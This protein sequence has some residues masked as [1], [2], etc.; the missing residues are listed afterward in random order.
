M[1]K[2]LFMILIVLFAGRAFSRSPLVSNI[3]VDS[4]SPRVVQI[5][6]DVYNH[7]GK[8]VDMEIY[9]STDGGEHYTKRLSSL[10]GDVRNVESGTNKLIK[11]D[12]YQDL[13]AVHGD[14]FRLKVVAYSHPVER[15]DIIVNAGSLGAVAAALQAARDNPEAEILLLEP[16]DWLGGQAT[17][18][19]VSAIDN[20]YT[21]HM[22]DTPE[23][24]AR[25]WMEFQEL[26]RENPEEAPGTG[27]AGENACWVSRFSYDPR[28]GAWAFE[29]MIE[30][31]P[32]ITYRDMSVVKDVSTMPV[33]DEYGDGKEITALEIIERTP[34]NDYEPFDRFLSEE[35]PDWYSYEDS[36]YFSKETTVILPQDSGKGMTVIDGSEF[37][38]IIVLADARYTVGRELET[39]EI[40]EDGEL[41]ELNERGTQSFVFTF[42]VTGSEE[43]D[44]ADDV[45]EPFPGFMDYYEQQVDDYFSLGT[46]SWQ[47]VWTYR[48]VLNAGGPWEMDTVNKDDVSMQNWYPGNDY[49]YGTLYKNIE[50][51]RKEKDDW[52]GGVMLDEIEQAEKHALAYY[53]YYRDIKPEEIPFEIY[54]L[55]GDDE[56]NM[57][58]THSGLSKKPYFRGTRRIVGLNNFRI[59][60][61]FYNTRE[62]AS[63]FYYDSIGIGNY[64]TDIHPNHEYDFGITPEVLYPEPFYIPYRSLASHN[65]RNL[66][67]AGKN[68]ATTFITNAGYRLH[69]IEWA[70]GVGAGGAAA[71]MDTYDVTNYDL[72][73]IPLLRELQANVKKN[74]PLSWP[75]QDD[76]KMPEITGDVVINDF[77]P[78]SPGDTFPI[79]V[80]HHGSAKVKA[81]YQGGELETSHEKVNGRF[82]IED[83]VIEDPLKWVRIECYDEEGVYME[84]LTVNEIGE[85]LTEKMVINNNEPVYTSIPFDIE[86]VFPVADKVALYTEEGFL[87][88]QST[89]VDGTFYFDSVVL[90][91]R[92]AWIEARGYTDDDELVGTLRQDIAY[93]DG[94]IMVNEGDLPLTGEEVQI[95][96]SHQEAAEIKLLI[97]GYTVGESDVSQN[98]LFEFYHTFE[99]AGKYSLEALCYDTDGS[100][101]DTLETTVESHPTDTFV[102]VNKGEDVKAFEPFTVKVYHP[103]AHSAFITAEDQWERG[104]TRQRVGHYLLWEDEGFNTPGDRWIAVYCYDRDGNEIDRLVAEFVVLPE[105]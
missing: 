74:S 41:P 73:D 24:Y 75:E 71:L 67:A 82:L 79:E 14:D 86:V 33:F 17:S 15:Y 105:D 62:D 8:P 48:R 9:L 39:E 47:R 6:Y 57:M 26:V 34:I 20:A 97:D 5:N 59:T 102:V 22:V 43:F 98:G 78:P 16:T 32:N 89:P 56:L 36:P 12:A 38:D 40:G 55:R 4:S 95:L 66:L 65:V 85:D 64:P 7:R 44:E 80:Y 76:S 99:E 61:R 42:C 83:N 19:G 25:D 2:I 63:H 37:G 88:K 93:E 70:A 87:E 35:I 45:K 92:S 52:Q 27:F 11:W 72:L 29:K 84:S 10:E 3:R 30:E 54:L 104:E 51:A 90:D 49:P 77:A 28:T 58:D 91:H 53:F 21:T 96:V 13:G 18:Q 68:Y 100:L 103:T 81:F 101:L 60:E 31:K 94:F 1:R 69:P 23:F 46:H 50:E